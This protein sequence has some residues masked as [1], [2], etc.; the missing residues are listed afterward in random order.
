MLINESLGVLMTDFNKVK[1]NQV[2]TLLYILA[3][4]NSR[5]C[6]YLEQ[7][8]RRYAENYY[9]TINFFLDLNLIVTTNGVIGIRPRLVSFIENLSTKQ[10]SEEEVRKFILQNLTEEMNE[11]T[12]QFYEYIDKFKS[13]DGEFIY[14]PL[15]RENIQYSGIRNFL[16]ELDVVSLR[17]D[18]N[19]YVIQNKYISELRH[20]K[21]FLSPA[22][23]NRIQDFQQEVGD[24]AELIAI[25]EEKKR[26]WETP[27]LSQQVKHISK[28]IVNAGYD[29]ESY[30]GNIIRDREPEKRFIEVKAVKFDSP[31]FFWSR[32]EIEKSRELKEQYWLYLVPYQNK[33]DFKRTLIERINDPYS[34]FFER[35]SEWNSCIELFSF[36]KSN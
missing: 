15:K 11:L 6:S 16:M 1:F 31:R 27:E 23:F 4:N 5:D 7:I 3:S 25:E 18:E 22:I 20:S 26:L 35:R 13:R 24:L 29:I 12:K 30:D 2:S 32:N 17:G 21:S 14:T 33:D 9:E 28:I 34:F 19:I 10:G 8:F 36:S